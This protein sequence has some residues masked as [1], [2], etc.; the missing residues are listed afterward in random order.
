MQLTFE[1]VFEK[2]KPEISG[3]IH[4]G[5]HY[6]EEVHSYIKHGVPNVVFFEPLKSNFYVLQQNIKDYSDKV[7]AHQVALGDSNGT[8]T[9][10]I[11]DNYGQSSSILNPK[12]H[13][14]AHPEVAFV[15]TEDVELAKLDDYNY[16]YNFLVIDVQGYELSV[17]KGATETLK[18]VDYIYCEV[19]QDEVYE[20]NALIGEIDSFLNEYEFKRVE[21]EW[22]CTQVWGN[23]FYIKEKSA[24]SLTLKDKFK[25][26]PLTYYI[27]LIES[28]NRREILHRAFEKMDVGPEK[29][30]PI[31]SP[32]FK[33]ANDIFTGRHITHVD[34]GTIGCVISHLKAL[35]HFY[36]ETDEPVVFVCEDDILFDTAEYWNFTWEEFVNSLPDDWDCV[37]LM[38]VR[39]AIDE[40]RPVGLRPRY[41]DDWAATGYILTREHAKKIIDAYCV[42]D[43][44]DLHIKYANLE[45]LIENII[46]THPGN[47]Y[48]I[49]LF[50]ENTKEINST[51]TPPDFSDANGIV[52]GQK[53]GHYYTNHILLEWWKNNGLKTSLEELTKLP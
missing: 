29:I 37:Q 25:N 11:S 20:G 48:C 39:Q 49:S 45:P 21:T 1:S 9:M 8:V 35:K 13:L 27:S 36:Y 46:F 47:T 3:L 4:I 15:G 14:T 5:A 30:R 34:G 41:W 33:D 2:Y 24:K 32:R 44:Y 31:L 23:A 16:D 28:E 22:W 19:N 50:T 10:N 53:S 18:N 12:V 43:V 26:F 38:Y 42:N 17:L 7:I 51:F 6:G 52:Q 40:H